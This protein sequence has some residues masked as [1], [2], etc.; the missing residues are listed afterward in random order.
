MTTK[1]KEVDHIPWVWGSVP[2]ALR[3]RGSPAIIKNILII[4]NPTDFG[5]TVEIGADPCLPNYPLNLSQ[6]QVECCSFFV[7]VE[8]FYYELLKLS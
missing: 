4:K 8:L 1:R 2:R 7:K 6:C 3:A 5:K